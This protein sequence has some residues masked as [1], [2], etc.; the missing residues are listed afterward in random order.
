[1]MDIGN[2]T[3]RRADLCCFAPFLTRVIVCIEPSKL[4]ILS[5]DSRACRAIFPSHISYHFAQL[6]MS[7]RQFIRT[8]VQLC[9][10]INTTAYI[11]ITVGNGSLPVPYWLIIQHLTGLSTA[12]YLSQQTP[13]HLQLHFVLAQNQERLTGLSLRNMAD[14]KVLTNL[15]L[16]L[17]VLTSTILILMVAYLAVRLINRHKKKACQQ[18]AHEP[19]LLDVESGRES[20]LSHRLSRQQIQKEHYEDLQQRYSSVPPS[21]SIELLPEIKTSSS[22]ERA[23]EW[24]ERGVADEGINVVQGD[25][26]QKKPEM[27]QAMVVR[28]KKQLRWDWRDGKLDNGGVPLKPRVIERI[29]KDGMACREYRT[30]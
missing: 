5:L 11:G 3:G 20:R 18:P 29:D 16:A 15:F 22:D 27:Q 13:H 4:V 7:T 14:A 1:M 28:P 30:E 26:G 10:C 9:S 23:S 19:T 17:I 12:V 8:L 24:L 21:P 6:N 25:L 2:L